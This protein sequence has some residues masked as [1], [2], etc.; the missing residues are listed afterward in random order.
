MRFFCWAVV[1]LC[2]VSAALPGASARVVLA[3]VPIGRADLPWWGHRHEDKLAELHRRKVELVFLGD[4]ITQDWEL[5]AFHPVWEHYYGDRQA[6]NLGFKGDTTA[7]VL[8]RIDHGEV[9]GIDPKVVVLLIGANNMGRP[10][11]GAVDTVEGIAAILSQLRGRLPHTKLLLLSVLPSQRSSWITRTT[12]EINRMLAETYGARQV[13]DVTYLD[14]TKVFM[15]DGRLDTGLFLD[16]RM[17]PPE[18]PLHP[19]PEGAAL[20]A[21]AM[22]PTLAAMLGD[23]QHAPMGSYASNRQ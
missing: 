15:R 2:A 3:A 5:P 4:S 7:S 20:L 21:A 9:A 18:A 10:H 1:L 13:A 12:A 11:W 23:R 22:E 6:I 17:R 19:D 16:P 8:W 14:M